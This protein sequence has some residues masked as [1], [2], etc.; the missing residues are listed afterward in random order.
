MQLLHSYGHHCLHLFQ[1]HIFKIIW[2]FRAA[3]R[4]AQNFLTFPK[5]FKL[6]LLFQSLFSLNKKKYP[7]LSLSCTVLTQMLPLIQ[8]H[9]RD[10][11]ICCWQH[12]V[13]CLIALHK[14]FPTDNESMNIT[15]LSNKTTT[16]HRQVMIKKNN[17]HLQKYSF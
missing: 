9:C 14:I 5:I 15:L 16:N 6:S 17:I 2:K 7:G 10:Y 11:Y 3:L 13:P 12:R 1:K 4:A 8:S